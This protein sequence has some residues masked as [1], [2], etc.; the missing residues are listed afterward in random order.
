VDLLPVLQRLAEDVGQR[1]V[2]GLSGSD[3]QL[4]LLFEGAVDQCIHVVF[5]VAEFSE[6]VWG[7]DIFHQPDQSVR[8]GVFV[9]V[10]D[11]FS[12]EQLGG[13]PVLLGICGVCGGRG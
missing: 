13:E 5:I 4:S 7:A 8:E 9:G 6:T 2:V 3:G 10:G 11:L 12:C 1:G